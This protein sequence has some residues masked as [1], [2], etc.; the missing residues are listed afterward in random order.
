MS[1]KTTSEILIHS[2]MQRTPIKVYDSDTIIDAVDRMREHHISALP[3][4]DEGGYL[5]GILTVND[6]LRL[7]Q[8]AGSKVM[9]DFP[10]YE[11]CYWVTELIRETLGTN[12]VT[13]AMTA[14]P[15]E[16]SLDDTL[17]DVSK[18]MVEHQVHHV[19]VVGTDHKLLGII[20]TIDMVRLI[21]DGVLD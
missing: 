12:E 3:V 1:T 4:I 9:D 21:A 2:V 14:A 13:S 6:L 11:D 20:T 17:K 10:L 18:L 5:Q 16:A 8:D 19:P 7:V 15:V